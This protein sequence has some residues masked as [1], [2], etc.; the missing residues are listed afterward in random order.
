MTKKLRV[1]IFMQIFIGVFLTVVHYV[2]EVENVKHTIMLGVLM[3]LVTLFVCNLKNNPRYHEKVI[4]IVL[5]ICY[6]FQAMW[7]VIICVLSLQLPLLYE[8]LI[9]YPVLFGAIVIALIKCKTIW[10][11]RKEAETGRDGER[12]ESN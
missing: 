4:D 12:N 1:K 7:L 11:I 5:N 9:C 3:V 10:K 8:D 6:M 2:L